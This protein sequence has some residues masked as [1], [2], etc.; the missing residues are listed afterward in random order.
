MEEINFPDKSNTSYLVSK[1][2]PNS[3][4]KSCTSYMKNGL[5]KNLLIKDNKVWIV[6]HLGKLE[7]LALADNDS[8]FFM[9]WL[10]F[11][12][13]TNLPTKYKNNIDTEYCWNILRREC[14]TIYLT[15]TNKCNSKCKVCYQKDNEDSFFDD[16][17]NLEDVELFLSKIGKNKNI[18]LFGGEP[19][20]KKDF[21]EIIKLIKKSDNKP[22]VFTNGLKL[23]DKK[24]V[25]NMKKCGIEKIRFSLDGFREDIYDKLRGGKHELYLKLKA[26]R[27]LESVGINVL[28]SSTI[29]QGVN[30]DQ[31]EDLLNFSI[32]NNNFVKSV[33]F[34]AGT[35]YHGKFD[36]KIDKILTSSDLIKRLEVCTN[37][38][39]TREYYL[40]FYRLKNNLN[41]FFEKFNIYFPKYF[42]G[43]FYKVCKG[44]LQELINTEDM[45]KI[46]NELEKGNYMKV[47]KY[48]IKHLNQFSIKN[49]LELPKRRFEVFGPDV[50][51]IYC[52]QLCTPLNYIPINRDSIMIAKN[53]EDLVIKNSG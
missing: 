24:F 10:S 51:H 40:E 39:I 42:S 30:E 27:N 17:M 19:T 3:I 5:F 41:T 32:R 6:N 21:F 33:F 4:R 15:V 12:K 20:I 14:N 26:L 43:V 47:F 18:M 46:N 53:D 35:P 36:V 31:I 13:K 44:E 37:K 1:V 7:V 34:F 2:S 8:N 52:G 11:R 16:E 9:R 29:V 28:I 48:S 23:A 49:L 50:L 45:I 22:L 25:K 38:N